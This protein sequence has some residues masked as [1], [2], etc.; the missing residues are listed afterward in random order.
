M[1]IQE[2]AMEVFL[3]SM[4]FRNLLFV[5]ALMICLWLLSLKLKDASIM[6]IF[7]GPGF[8]IVTWLTYFMVDGFWGRKLLVA[9]LI[10]LWGLRLALHIA[11]RNFG[12]GEDRRYRA[13]RVQYGNRFWWI[14]FFKVFFLQGIL[15]WV[16]SLGVQ[17]V[18]MASTPGKFV[19][20]DALGCAVWAIGFL[21]ETIGDWQLESFRSEPDSQG[22]VMNRGLWAYTRHPNYF[23]ESLIWWGIFL[24]SLTDISNFWT[25]ISPLVITFLL[26][27]VSG[28][29][30]LERDISKRRPDYQAYIRRTPAFVPWFPKKEANHKTGV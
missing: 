19:W 1:T 10:S 7:W 16:I 21:F 25:V 11:I 24:I 28:V 27:K 15:L 8:V 2:E 22:K 5:M 30:M 3:S 14:S 18:Q 23:G 20:L 29:A 12:K 17:T 13:W 6:D 26:L 4:Y 9:F